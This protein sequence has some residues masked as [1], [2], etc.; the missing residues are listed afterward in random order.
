M[1]DNE[2]EHG[3]DRTVI[4]DHSRTNIIFDF[5][6]HGSWLCVHEY[7]KQNKGWGRGGGLG[8]CAEVGGQVD[9]T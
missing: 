9:K 2:S 7:C 8:G 6:F 5:L 3:S 4:F 1:Y